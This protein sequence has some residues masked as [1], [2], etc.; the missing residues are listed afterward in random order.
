MVRE[1]WKRLNDSRD[2]EVHGLWALVPYQKYTY[3]IV[4]KKNVS[5]FETKFMVF[6]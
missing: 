2:S 5:K 4:N 1:W 6:N 3:E